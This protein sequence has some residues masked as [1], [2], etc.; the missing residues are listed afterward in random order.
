MVRIP[1]VTINGQVQELPTGDTILVGNTSIANGIITPPAITVH[2]NDYNPTGLSTCNV[3]RVSSTADINLTGLVAQASGTLIYIFNVGTTNKKV[4]LKNDDAAS[5]FG[6]RFYIRTD[7]TIET[8]EAA[9][10]WYDIASSGWRL[11]SKF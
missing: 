6:N 2:T 8:N 10:L 5:L 9:L 4:K 1:L 11:V 7:A 3:M